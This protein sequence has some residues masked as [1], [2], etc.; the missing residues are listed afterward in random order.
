MSSR[1]VFLSLFLGLAS[2]MQSI[3]V[4]TDA[5]VKLVRIVLAGREIAALTQP[6]WHTVANFGTELDPRPIEAIGYE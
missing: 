3:D 6:P 1:V 4:Q 5:A 2:G